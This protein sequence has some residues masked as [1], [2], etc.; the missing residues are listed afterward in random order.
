VD[1]DEDC[2]DTTAMR[3]PGLTE[4]CDDLDNDCDDEVDEGLSSTYFMDADRDGY[5]DAADSIESCDP[6]ILYVTNDEDCDDT[7][8]LRAPGL[9]E[10]C[11]DLDNDC[12]DAVDEGVLSTFYRDADGDGHGDA[13]TTTAACDATTDYVASSDDCDDGSAARAPSLTEVCDG[14]DNDCDD[15]IDEGLMGTYYFDG[16]GDG[17]GDPATETTACSTSGSY[18][19]NDDDC[20]DTTAL[21]APGL[22]ETCDGIDNDCDESVD[23]GLMGTYY[24]DGDGDGYGDPTDSI[25]ACSSDGS[26]VTNDD[27]CDD[28][29]EATS[30]YA[31]EECDGKDND[32]DGAID[33]GACGPGDEYVAD[34]GGT[35]IK[36]D[37]QTF[38][39]GCTA[40]MSS[41]A[42]HES[43]AHD[44]TLTNDFYIGETEVTQAE[45][46]AMMGTN[47]SYFSS[48]GSDCP[49]EQVSWHM[50]AAFA[51]AVSDSEGLEQCYT[52]IG[53]E[54][55]TSCTISVD[56][57]SCGG[58][59]LP[60]EAEW[61]AAARCGED[62]LYAGSTVIGDV[63][64]YSG[65]SG[66]TPHTVATKASNA[67]GLYDMSGNVWEWSQDWY[68]SSYYSSSPGTDPGGPTSGGNRVYRG[69]SWSS[70]PTYARVAVRGGSDPTFRY[71]DFGLRLARTS[72]LSGIGSLIGADCDEE[73]DG[74]YDCDLE[75]YDGWFIDEDGGDWLGDDYCDDGGDGW[76]PD[77]NCA[78]F[79][80]DEGDCEP[81]LD[82][83]LMDG[84]YGGD[85]ESERIVEYP[86]GGLESRYSCDGPV[87]AEIDTSLSPQIW[88]S[89]TCVSEY[90][91]TEYTVDIEGNFTDEVPSGTITFSADE[92]I[93]T[94]W[95]G[96][97]AF[98]YLEATFEGDLDSTGWSTTRYEGEFELYRID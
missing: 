60:T 64:W 12:D 26:Y 84:E 6:G 13:G 66:S 45:Y 98:G 50:S 7:T 82:A 61:E 58:Y 95:V 34:H 65:N 35:M 25:T 51:N 73:E 8:A 27:D 30:P 67:C 38:E 59:R 91:G 55:S 17:Y 5:G 46:E 76:E 11:D 36:I 42:A 71:S 47:P 81:P 93:S 14:V 94:D 88:G 1:N 49:V 3:A 70:D 19:T 69:G 43:P 62:T 57:Y 2:D 48:C 72:P 9:T 39:M 92:V 54:A 56:P 85:F 40:G 53:S 4:T 79:D 90:D 29:D 89:S 96:T 23:E 80:F 22:P 74:F 86:F 87:A 10:T 37:A 63:A 28:A 41:C 75:C 15:E 78:E 83:F 18:V 32:C 24:F 52:C 21:R 44:V 68:S 20:D 16:D 33:D 77:L 97:W 31:I